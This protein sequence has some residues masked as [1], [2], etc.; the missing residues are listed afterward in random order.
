MKGLFLRASA[1]SGGVAGSEK[2]ERMFEDDE[3][4]AK[5]KAAPATRPRAQREAP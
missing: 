2:V 3:A 1:D 4:K 5:K